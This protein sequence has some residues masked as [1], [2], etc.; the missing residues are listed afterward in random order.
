MKKFT[1]ELWA[2][3]LPVYNLIEHHPF[4]Q[5]LR[6]GTLSEERFKFYIYQ[7]AL[8]LG[9]FARSLATI[10]TRATSTHMLLDFLQFAQNA[11]LVE[12][13]LHHSYFREFN[14]QNGAGKAPAC[15]A[16]TH[17]LLSVSA[18]ESYE[19]AIAAHLPCFWIYKKIGDSILA[20]QP[21]GSNP[22]QNWID[23]YAGEEF[24]AS[25][26]KAIDICNQTAE[27]TTPEVRIKM[28]EAYLTASRLEYMFW[29]SAYKLE[30]WFF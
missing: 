4:N 17:Y 18:F 7:D 20:H 28:K 26:Q 25:V 10:G 22:Y 29:D 30:K 12:R 1:D 15:F 9:D 13:G 8:Y 2:E 21:S 6:K 16:Y 5:E 11:V 3:A 19:V 27:R 23:A 24:A 14:I